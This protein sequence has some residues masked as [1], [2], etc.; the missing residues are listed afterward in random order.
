MTHTVA[1]YGSRDLT[2][3]DLGTQYDNETFDWV[4]MGGPVTLIRDVVVTETCNKCHDPLALHGGSRREIKVCV[5]CH[6]PQTTD[7][8]YGEHCGHE[9][10]DP[11]DSRRAESSKCPGETR[12]N[13][14]N[15]SMA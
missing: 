14:R 15:T 8:D 3:F 12:T 9:G 10:I 1:L 7:P 13:L 4:P 6:T 2:E 5:T 11:Q